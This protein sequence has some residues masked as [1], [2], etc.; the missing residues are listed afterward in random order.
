[1]AVEFPYSKEQQLKSNRKPKPKERRYKKKKN[2][3]LYRGRI[4]PSRKE[5]T[6]ITEAN[7]NR[8]I[9]EFGDYCMACGYTPI[10]AHHLVFR[11]HMGTG[12]WRNLA[13]LCE[14]C[15]TRAHKQKEFADLLREMRAERFG[16]HFGKDV[17]TLFKEGLINNTTTEAY[18][19]FMKSEE[20]KCLTNGINQIGLD[21]RRL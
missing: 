17:Y 3:Y 21:G 8:M 4:I 13:P 1:M 15:H 20:E 11:S 12:N 14:K 5:R 6:K 18:E 2:P 7:Y 10:A 9:E 19:S 16:E